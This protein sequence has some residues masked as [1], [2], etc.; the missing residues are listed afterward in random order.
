VFPQVHPLATGKTSFA[1]KAVEKP[2]EKDAASRRQPAADKEDATGGELARLT[3]SSKDS[4]DARAN[5][6]CSTSD[7]H[8]NSKTSFKNHLDKFYLRIYRKHGYFT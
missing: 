6:N 8:M 5:E 1:I 2:M 4:T 3:K 7:Q